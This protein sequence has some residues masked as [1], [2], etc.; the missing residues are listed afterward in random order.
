MRMTFAAVPEPFLSNRYPIM[1]M[2]VR[3]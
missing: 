1:G 2:P 3:V